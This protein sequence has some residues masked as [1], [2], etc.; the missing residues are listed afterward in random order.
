MRYLL[1]LHMK[2]VF[3]HKQYKLFQSDKIYRSIMNMAIIQVEHYMT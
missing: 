3:K 2:D 1:K